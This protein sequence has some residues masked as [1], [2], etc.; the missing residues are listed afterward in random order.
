MSEDIISSLKWCF[1]GLLYAMPALFLIAG[2]V[3]IWKDNK[4][5]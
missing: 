5:K 4:N 3:T 1:L 2:I